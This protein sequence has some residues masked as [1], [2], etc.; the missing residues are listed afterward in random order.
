MELFPR[1]YDEE[2]TGW[3]N[4]SAEILADHMVKEEYGNILKEQFKVRI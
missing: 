3:E 1:I 4:K 2:N